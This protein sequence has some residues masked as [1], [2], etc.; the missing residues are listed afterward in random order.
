MTSAEGEATCRGRGHMQSFSLL[1]QFKRSRKEKERERSF[2]SVGHGS[3]RSAWDAPCS[4]LRQANSRGSDAWEFWRGL[5][6]GASDLNS[7]KFCPCS[8]H[9]KFLDFQS[10]PREFRYAFTRF[11]RKSY[12]VLASLE[13]RLLHSQKFKRNID[14]NSIG[15]KISVHI[16][17][18]KSVGKWLQVTVFSSYQCLAWKK[19]EKKERKKKKKKKFSA[20]AGDRS[21]DLQVMSFQRW[22]LHHGCHSYTN[23]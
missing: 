18:L 17:I 13:P 22:P 2:R 12:S 6:G 16:W 9:S 11:A 1:G 14:L 5:Y 21:T 19:E 7:W 20:L 4:A 8:R 10:I 15:F 23:M 3:Y